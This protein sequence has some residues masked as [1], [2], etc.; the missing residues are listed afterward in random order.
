MKTQTT[1]YGLTSESMLKT[2][3]VWR[4]FGELEITNLVSW[5]RS[6]FKIELSIKVLMNYFFISRLLW[7]IIFVYNRI[8][9][10]WSFVAIQFD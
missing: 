1:L 3:N 8:C 9:T 7:K 6:P 2:I 10:S 4:M 5:Q